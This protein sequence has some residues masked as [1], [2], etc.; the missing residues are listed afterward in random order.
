ML[1]LSAAFDTVDHEILAN[2][3]LTHFGVEG[4][5]LSWIRS[6]LSDRT[7]RVKCGN[8]IGDTVGLKTG[9]PQGSI[10]GPILFNCYMSPLFKILASHGVMFHNYADDIQI[11]CEYDPSSVEGENECRERLGRVLDVVVEWM[12]AHYLKLN[13]NKTI[14]IPISRHSANSFAP[15]HFGGNTILPSCEARN[16]GFIFDSSFSFVSQISNTRKNAFYQLKR[17]QSC[18]AFIPGHHLSTLVHAFVTSRL[19][20]CNS[21]YFGLPLKQLEKLQSILTAAAKFITGAKKH[22]STSTALASLHWLPIHER[23]KYKMCIIGYHLYHNTPHYP[24]YFSEISP[25]ARP[26]IKTR[27]SDI[28]SLLS[29]FRPKL[30]NLEIDLPL[31]RLLT[32]LILCPHPFA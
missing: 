18:K 31:V 28:P 32:A 24:V 27:S 13:C 3:L 23:I 4:H 15:F 29:S 16:L 7:F 12:A 2:T 30:K 20:F 8:V 14:F 6:Y 26:N 25:P 9:V 22:D 10:L 21:L 17:L 11:W 5:A 19:D 1:D